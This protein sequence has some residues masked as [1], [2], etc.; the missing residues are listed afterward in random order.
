MSHDIHCI[1]PISRHCHA[2]NLP[3]IEQ[4]TKIQP[5]Q[6]TFFLSHFSSF[7]AVCLLFKCCFVAWQ[8]GFT[9]SLSKYISIRLNLFVFGSFGSCFR[10]LAVILF[11]IFFLSFFLFFFFFFSF[12]LF[13]LSSASASIKYLYCS[14]GGSGTFTIL[15]PRQLWPAIKPYK[16]IKQ[17][18]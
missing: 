17:A 12:F 7:L 14:N 6:D 1:T 10:A 5:K 8:R 9:V 16:P 18:P 2:N 11:E 15:F 3:S 4:A 13:F